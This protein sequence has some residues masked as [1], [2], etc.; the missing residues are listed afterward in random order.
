[1]VAL[2]LCPSPRES[3]VSEYGWGSTLC[4][5]VSTGEVI[6]IVAAILEL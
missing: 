1:M 4:G 2:P 3:A 6:L 5:V